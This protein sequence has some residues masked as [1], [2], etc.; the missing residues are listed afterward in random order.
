M[1]EQHPGDMGVPAQHSPV[2]RGAA[3]LGFGINIC[4]TLKQE[5]D[6]ILFMFVGWGSGFMQGG[7]SQNVRCLNICPC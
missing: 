7:I 2:E 5:P 6:D 3:V 1:F 4:S